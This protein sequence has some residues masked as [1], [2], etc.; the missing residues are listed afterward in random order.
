MKYLHRHT[1]DEIRRVP[2]GFTYKEMVA[3]ISESEKL[4]LRI[5]FYR[6]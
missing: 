1:P 5:C 3:A 4:C 2:Y 6:E